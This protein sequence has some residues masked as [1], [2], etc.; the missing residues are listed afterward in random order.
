M[1]KAFKPRRSAL[2]VPAA[3]VRALEKARGL[4]A[5][6]I[7]LDLEDAVAPEE[8]DAAR[9]RAME[10]VPGYA[11]RE[12]VIRV[13]AA[14]TLWHAADMAAAACSGAGALLLPKLTG[15]GEIAAAQLQARG[16]PLWAMIETPRALLDAPAIADAG[17]QCLVL[18]S[19]DML[20]AM[21][22]RHRAD[23]ANLHTTMSLTVLAARAAG[24]AVLDGVHN[25]LDAA[26]EFAHAC[27]MARDFGFDG[28][29]VIH[30]SQIAT[31]NRA[32]SPTT[33]EIAYARRVLEAFAA[34]PGKGVITLD[35][36]MLEAL[37]ADIA[38]RTLA[39]AGL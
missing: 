14:G 34:Q 19:N 38:A 2:F 23:R 1:S 16:I 6:V 10:A 32:F 20:H 24:I 31:A 15:P 9:A 33:E 3:N 39:R 21:E 29:S 13:N 11:P 36:R 22:G 30:P 28:K 25:D 27:A 12:T 37:D 26:E 17:V 18:G 35:R 4:P 5:D 8:K 7:I